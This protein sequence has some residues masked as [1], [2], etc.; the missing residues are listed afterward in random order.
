MKRKYI[1]P[2]AEIVLLELTE[3]IVT[4]SETDLPW[5][6]DLTGIPSGN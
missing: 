2:E 5:D 3:D 1:T 6:E 4:S